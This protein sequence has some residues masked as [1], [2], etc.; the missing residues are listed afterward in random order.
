MGTH[1]RLTSA[2]HPQS[3]G[4]TERFNQT[5]CKTLKKCV[6]ETTQEWDALIAS[7]LFAYRTT[8]NRTTKYEPFYLLYGRTPTLPIELDII[9]WPVEDISK[10]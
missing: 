8:K 10:K 4:L 2:Y 5:L 7:A 9:T 6:K 3:N 1:R